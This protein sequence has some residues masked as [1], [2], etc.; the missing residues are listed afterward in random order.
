[1]VQ[2]KVTKCPSDALSLTNCLIVNEHDFSPE[3]VKEVISTYML[4]E[5]DVPCLELYHSNRN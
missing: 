2:M 3:R 4:A 5:V 1:M